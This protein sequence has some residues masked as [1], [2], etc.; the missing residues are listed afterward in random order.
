MWGMTRVSTS[1]CR[2]RVIAAETAGLRS[3][4]PDADAVARLLDEIEHG[5]L[6]KAFKEPRVHFAIVCASL[7]CPDLRAEPF[8]AARLD[9]QLGA[10]VAP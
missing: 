8:E 4:M 7:S 6:R 5:I 9:A 10:G 1:A 2:S 3:G